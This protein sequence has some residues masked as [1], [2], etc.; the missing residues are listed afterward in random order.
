MRGVEHTVSLFFSDISKI[1]ILN[2]MISAHRMIYNSFGSS[3]Y[4][5]PHYIFKSKSQE[6]HYKNI[7]IF[8]GND[9]IMAG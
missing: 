1:F 3:I 2:Q 5:K 7:G 6:F 8:S 9:T 4:H